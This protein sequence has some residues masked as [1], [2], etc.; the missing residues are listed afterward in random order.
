MNYDYD[1]DNNI[2]I[3]KQN[4]EKRKKQLK[5]NK[6]DANNV[7]N[8]SFFTDANNTYKEN[9]TKRSKLSKNAKKTN[10]IPKMYNS[11]NQSD[12]E[13]SDTKSVQG[14]NCSSDNSE[15]FIGKMDKMMDNRK[16]ERKFVK[17]TA[18]NNNFTRQFDQMTFSNPNAPVSINA[19]PD[20]CGMNSAISRMENERELSLNEGFS[21]FGESGDMTYGITDKEHFTHNNM[22]PFYKKGFTGA[23][24][25][26]MNDYSQRKVDLFTGSKRV[27]WNNKTEQTPLF[28][29]VVG[30]KNIYGDMPI[31]DLA[32][33]RYIPGKEKRNELPFTQIKVG[34]GLGLNKNSSGSFMKGSGDLYRVIPKNIDDLRVE[35]KKR[36]IME[37]V[38]NHGM[39]GTN[40]PIAGKMQKKKPPKVWKTDPKDMIKTYS[41]VGAPRVNSEIL[42]DK[43]SKTRGLLRKV[44]FGPGQTNVAQHT[45]QK[46]IAKERQ[47]FKQVYNN[48]PPT[49]I[50]LIDGLRDRSSTHDDTYIPDATQRV[51]ENKHHGHLNA[52]TQ[53]GHTYDVIT[54]IP[55]VNMRNIHQDTKYNGLITGDMRQTT[56]IDYNDTPDQ[57]MRNIHGD[58]K[59]ANGITGNMQKTHTYDPN[60]LM[61]PNMRVIHGAIDREGNVMGNHMNPNVYDPNDLPNQTMRNIHGESKRMGIV[62]ADYKKGYIFDP[63]DIPDVTQ[64]EIYSKAIRNGVL[65]GDY[66]KANTFDLN[67]LPNVTMREIH[68]ESKR[69][70]TV[71]GEIGKTHTF[72]PN[73]TPEINMRNIHG[74]TKQNG[75]VIGDYQKVNTYDINDVPEINMRNIHGKTKQNGAMTGDYK[76]V[77]TYDPNDVPEVNMRN[78]HGQTKQNGAVTGDYK[79]V[80]IYDP[81]DVPNINMR[82]IHGQTKQNGVITG[83]YKKN[84]VYDPNDIPDVNMRNVHGQTKQNGVITGDYKKNNVYDPNDVPDVNMRNIHGEI[85]QNGNMTGDSQKIR[86]FDPNDIPDAT[87]R[88]IHGKNKVHGPLKSDVN[89]AYTINYVNATPDATMRDI[90]G[91]NKVAGPLK[92]DIESSYTINYVN[93]TPD[94]T[95]REIQGKTNRI[96]PLQ[97]DITGNYTINYV[98][99]TPD[100]TIREMTGKTNHVTPGKTLVDAQP[101]RRDAYNGKVNTAKEATLKGRTPTKISYDVGPT[102]RFTQYYL[103]EEQEP[104]HRT[105]Q[106]SFPQIINNLDFDQVRSKSPT[107]FENTRTNMHVRENLANNPYIN[108]IVH[109][110]IIKYNL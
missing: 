34:P 5:I 1:Y 73:D 16:H 47:P 27:D 13:F 95:I 80:N 63:N 18:D 9:I 104:I 37:G 67:D 106:P 109:K 43:M 45:D 24:V 75:V 12:S 92:S 100:V 22:T 48:A 103:K 4:L 90:H 17:K 8:R 20:E 64:R 51:V 21:N 33:G 77:N 72:D 46:L 87:M 78:I 94:V 107:S 97:S 65:T 3:E 41:V 96:G 23:S 62:E 98:N 30:M 36:I 102:T 88:D 60:D 31:T 50:Q 38:T 105:N 52:E 49:N 25:E 59:R 79:K 108:N 56:T 11:F 76:K 14:S 7:Y 15:D 69:H 19:I 39:K 89:N 70:G 74:K 6:G 99:A 61:A 93:A 35:G 86:T 32:K 54:S 68:G 53:K 91:K 101:N 2:R 71:M 110:S 44:R 84:N 40:G 57:N 83:D 26:H 81:N 42:K 58:L 10:V 82:N 66:K 29:P 55:D 85:K 28:S